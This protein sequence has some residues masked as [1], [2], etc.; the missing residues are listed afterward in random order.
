[1]AR[2]RRIVVE[3]VA[4]H[5]THRGNRKHDIFVDDVDRKAYLQ[6]LRDRA[7]GA[8]LSVWAYVLM[9]NHVHLVCVPMRG[10]SLRKTVGEAHGEYASYFNARHRLV[11]HLWQGRYHSAALDDAHLYAA[12]RYVERNPV[13]AGLCGLRLDQRASPLSTASR[14]AAVTRS[15]TAARHSRLVCVAKGG[16]VASNAGETAHQH[17]AREADRRG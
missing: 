6:I 8:G 14:R 4:H 17:F 12:T 10:D 11:G 13:R 9:S 5:V 2:M 3:G 15:P 7:K 1:M 16:R